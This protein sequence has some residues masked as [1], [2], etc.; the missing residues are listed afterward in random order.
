MTTRRVN[1]E[2]LRT[3]FSLQRTLRQNIDDLMKVD[4][5]DAEAA[6]AVVF[7]IEAAEKA[8]ENARLTKHRIHENTL[9]SRQQN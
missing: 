5:E 1:C 8:I 2:A 3:I 6:K 7:A 4:C 9:R